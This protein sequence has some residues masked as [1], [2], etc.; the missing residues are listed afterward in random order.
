MGAVFFILLSS[1]VLW[2]I[3]KGAKKGAPMNAQAFSALA[4]GGVGARGLVLTSSQ[5]STGVRSGGR[6]FERRTMTIEVEIPGKPP[7]ITSGAFLVPRGLV[8]GI[9]GSSLEL[10]VDPSDQSS[11]VILG[12]GG[13]T[14]PWL[15]SGPP[16]P[17]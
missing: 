3:F 2:L 14:G 11:L 6:R 5:L 17:Y 16:R 1:F 7:Y 15:Q 10:S 13:F 8:E 9:P 12:P 4:R